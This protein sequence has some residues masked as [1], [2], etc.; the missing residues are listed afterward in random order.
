MSAHKNIDRICVIITAITIVIALV[1][2][3]GK[4][5][6]L[7]TT[8]HAMGYED[9]LFDHSKV[10]TIDIVMNDWEGFILEMSSP[11]SESSS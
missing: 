8:A 9:R 1:F 3:N 2:C 5:L 4:A 11:G 7:Q 10:H 6:G